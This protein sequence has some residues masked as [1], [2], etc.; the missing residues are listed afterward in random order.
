MTP[1]K[2]HPRSR[3]TAAD[4]APEMTVEALRAR[5]ERCR[6]ELLTA[7]APVRQWL[8]VEPTEKQLRQLQDD[9]RQAELESDKLLEAMAKL[10]KQENV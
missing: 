8:A 9:L 5:V 1:A 4:R 6:V 7:M 2:P 10:R 3:R